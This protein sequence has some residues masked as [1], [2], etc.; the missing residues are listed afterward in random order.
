MSVK[1]WAV[2][3]SKHSTIELGN[4]NF[5]Q[6]WAARNC[7]IIPAECVAEFFNNHPTKHKR[8]LEIIG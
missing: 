3:G 1:N 5:V 7:N 2:L 4:F 8:H 6:L